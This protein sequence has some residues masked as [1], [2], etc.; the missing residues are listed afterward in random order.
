MG[1]NNSEWDFSSE[2]S[3]PDMSIFDKKPEE[4]KKKIKKVKKL[5]KMKMKKIKLKKK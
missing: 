3:E 1:E 2:C 5:C 4:P